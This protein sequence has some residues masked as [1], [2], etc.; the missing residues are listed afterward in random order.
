MALKARFDNR[1][2]PPAF[3]Y[4][5]EDGVQHTARRI[6]W[7]FLDAKQDETLAR[8]A[9]AKPAVYTEA[10]IRAAQRL[11]QSRAFSLLR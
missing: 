10:E 6:D 2:L 9:A 8:V 3:T 1:N 7:S 5:D 4:A 11:N